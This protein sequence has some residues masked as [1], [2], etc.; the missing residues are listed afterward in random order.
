MKQYQ[1]EIEELRR[2][3]EEVK[4]ELLWLKFDFFILG[5]L[6]LWFPRLEYFFGLLL[7]KVRNGS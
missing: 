3:L 5:T 7:F 4:P 2:L 1:K 6:T